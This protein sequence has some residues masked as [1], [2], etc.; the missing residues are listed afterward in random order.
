MVRLGRASTALRTRP[1]LLEKRFSAVFPPLESAM[2]LASAA[3]R[4]DC[5]AIFAP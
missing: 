1:A 3:S 4:L 5:C 2:R